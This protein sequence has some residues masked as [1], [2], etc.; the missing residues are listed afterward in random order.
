MG[1]FASSCPDLRYKYFSE[2][3]TGSVAAWIRRA[4]H[5]TRFSTRGLGPQT[6]NYVL[7]FA[8]LIRGC[9]VLEEMFRHWVTLRARPLSALSLS[10][11]SLLFRAPFCDCDIPLLVHDINSAF[12]H[13]VLYY[14]KFV[15]YSKILSIKR[16]LIEGHAPSPDPKESFKEYPVR[17]LSLYFM[18]IPRAAA[19][20]FRRRSNK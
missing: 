4:R 14:V 9:N 2:P 11:R 3:T 5:C 17:L 12:Y 10:S 6:T 13:V 1:G 16:K 18:C 19:R 15:C 8:Y 20:L 7:A